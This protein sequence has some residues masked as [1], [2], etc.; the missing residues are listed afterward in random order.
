METSYTSSNHTENH[1]KD[2]S[3]VKLVVMTVLLNISK[4]TGSAGLFP[5][6]RHEESEVR[7]AGVTSCT[8]LLKPGWNPRNVIS[9][10][11]KYNFITQQTKLTLEA[12]P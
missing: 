7:H 1:R 12:A 8:M 10:E 6:R 2:L 4:G 3:P 9:Y 5:R 11:K